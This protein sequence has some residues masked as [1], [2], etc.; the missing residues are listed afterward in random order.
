[1]PECTQKGLAGTAPVLNDDHIR[2]F[3]KL[4]PYGARPVWT[5]A[6]S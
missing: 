3:Y 6:D 2:C 4:D 5:Q 1:L